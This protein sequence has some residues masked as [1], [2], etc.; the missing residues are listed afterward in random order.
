[1]QIKN[2]RVKCVKTTIPG[3]TLKGFGRFIISGEDLDL[4]INS[5][6][7]HQRGDEYFLQWPM[8]QKGKSD[9]VVVKPMNDITEEK[10]RDELVKAYRDSREFFDSF[11]TENLA[12]TTIEK[13]VGL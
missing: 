7:L 3:S 11:S 10:I 12:G 6:E 5:I 4:Q 9:Y 13:K 2:A 8:I 1:M